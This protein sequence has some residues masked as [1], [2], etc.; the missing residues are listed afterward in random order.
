MKIALNQIIKPLN[1]KKIKHYETGT[2]CRDAF[3]WFSFVFSVLPVCVLP[4][5]F[6]AQLSLFID[7][8]LFLFL[9]LIV[10]LV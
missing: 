3:F 6:W 2:N 8:D 10:F 9:L 4:L 7:F 5:L 1:K